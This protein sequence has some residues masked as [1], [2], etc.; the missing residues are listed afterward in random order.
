M[1]NFL[2]GVLLLPAFATAQ[3]VTVDKP[4][5]CEKTETVIKGLIGGDYKENPLW[6]GIDNNSKYSL[7]ANIKTGSWTLLQFD[8]KIAC[9]IGSGE[10]SKM[11]FSKPNT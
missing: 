9:V 1:R 6:V 8:D 7:F 4:V 10:K 2:L 11:I 5:Q 3:P